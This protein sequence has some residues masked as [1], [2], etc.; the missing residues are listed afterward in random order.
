MVNPTPTAV[1]I[2]RWIPSL[3]MIRCSATG[4]TIAL[5]TSA[6]DAVT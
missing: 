3:T 2:S 1:S 6:I 4:M 5:N